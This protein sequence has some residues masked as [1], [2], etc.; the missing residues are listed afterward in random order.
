MNNKYKIHVCGWIF[1]FKFLGIL[2]T[3][4][5]SVCPCLCHDWSNFGWFLTE[6]TILALKRSKI[7]IMIYDN[8]LNTRVS[9]LYLLKRF[10]SN[11]L[12]W[13]MHP[14][15]KLCT[16]TK[17]DVSLSYLKGTF[18]GRHIVNYHRKYSS[19][20]KEPHSDLQNTI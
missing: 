7:A 18:L 8:F 16:L 19:H 1:T 4:D 3:S 20:T 2:L 13:I 5:T 14:T 11:L 10:F 6:I 12:F 15:T 9:V 17:R